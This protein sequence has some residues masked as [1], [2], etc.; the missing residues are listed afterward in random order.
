MFYLYKITNKVNN[1]L[2]IGITTNI[3]RRW[4]AHQNNKGSRLVY[5][6][7]KKYGINNFEFTVIDSSETKE[8]REEEYSLIKEL[9]TYPPYGYNIAE[10]GIGGTTNN[11]TKDEISY[12]F[13]RDTGEVFQGN[14][15]DFYKRYNLD[16][17]AVSK[18]INK[19]QNTVKGWKV[20]HLIGWKVI[21]EL[22]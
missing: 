5:Q 3:S 14:R 4:K 7:I 20:F 6:A 16:R 13:Y 1:K 2:Y 11:Y 17:S 8:F 19:Q 12:F 9:N 15:S 18:L 22:S 21:K 10:G